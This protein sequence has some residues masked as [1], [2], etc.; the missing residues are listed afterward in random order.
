MKPERTKKIRKFLERFA[1]EFGE[2]WLERE[3]EK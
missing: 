1:A 2:G 3:V